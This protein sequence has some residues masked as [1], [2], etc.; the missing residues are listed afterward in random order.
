MNHCV[1]GNADHWSTEP[2]TADWRAAPARRVF[3][4]LDPS[5]MP[6]LRGCNAYVRYV[7]DFALFADRKAT[8][9]A[10]K[11]ALVERLGRL[12]LT[13]HEAAAQVTP[14]AHGI[15]WLGFIVYQTRRRVKGRNVR[16][17]THR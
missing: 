3:V 9:W 15:P 16:T 17:A 8:L 11:R 2:L 14:V 4:V 7:D 6:G 1:S 5:A 12:R 10:W 13:I